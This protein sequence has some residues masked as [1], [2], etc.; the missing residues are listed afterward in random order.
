M[1]KEY[2]SYH[3]KATRE[4]ILNCY[5]HRDYNRR[6][7]IKIEFFDDK[8]KVLFDSKVKSVTPG[9]I[10]V[11]YKDDECLGGGIIKEVRKDNKKMWYLS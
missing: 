9:Q 5:C 3:D 8:A 2:V 11:F 7:N 10:C 1:R 4:A 6:S